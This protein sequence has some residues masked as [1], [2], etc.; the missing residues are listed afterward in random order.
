MLGQ[1]LT[2]VRFTLQ[3]WPQGPLLI[4]AGEEMG[5]GELDRRQPPANVL[6]QSPE[7][8][9]KFFWQRKDREAERRAVLKQETRTRR[10]QEHQAEQ[11]AR[12]QGQPVI[13]GEEA[14]VDMAF[15][16][17]QRRGQKEPY[18]PGASLKGAMRS[19]AERLARSLTLSGEAACN[20]FAEIRG[21]GEH[22][23]W[24]KLGDPEA[25]G[26]QAAPAYMIYRQLCT[27]CR[28]FGAPFLA[29][30]LRVTDAYLMDAMTREGLPRRD[31][32]GI[33]RQRGAA[34]EGAKYDFEYWDGG[35]FQAQVQLQNFELWQVG[36]LAHVLHAL[37]TEKA[38]IGFGTRR[39]LG[40]V[41]VGVTNLQISYYGRLALRE[42]QDGL[43]LI[44]LGELATADAQLARYGFLAETT[45]RLA[46]TSVQAATPNGELLRR[47]WTVPTPDDLW[48]AVGTKWNASACEQLTTARL[49]QP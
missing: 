24:H 49:A 23:C 19:Y 8:Q 12:Q 4:K 7:E 35:G 32:V 25:A 21:E 46:P 41:R 13:V 28:L 40:R 27:V 47:T 10:Q 5:E 38:L 37:Q 43:P 26:R 15:V 14:V 34:A 3:L 16:R 17:T 29:G 18:L 31:G 2:E 30:R 11:A 44:G 9:M 42:Y 33:N 39:G 48:R 1:L 45:A 20:P 6:T 36:L 22:P